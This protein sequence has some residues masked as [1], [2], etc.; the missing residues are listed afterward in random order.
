MTGGGVARGGE[1][2]GAGR[3]PSLPPVI[4]VGAGTGPPTA[5]GTD[6]GWEL[7]LLT[8]EDPGELDAVLATV[9]EADRAA[10]FHFFTVVPLPLDEFVTADPGRRTYGL[11]R[12]D[13][14]LACTSVYAADPD[15]RTVM[16]GFT[17]TAPAWRGRGVNRAMKS[18]LFSTLA[19]AGVREVWFRADVENTASCRALERCGAERVR[20]DDA[21]RVYP[22]RVSR[23]VFYRRVL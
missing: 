5:T 8:G 15:A 12:G 4:P 22:D 23:S 3:W 18:A 13:E 20:V 16:A 6:G 9:P 17:W 14:A 21:P 11:F 2:G 10:T 19:D 7:R 1:A